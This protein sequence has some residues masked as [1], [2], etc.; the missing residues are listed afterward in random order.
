MKK[1]AVFACISDSI[2]YFFT[3]I[4]SISFLIIQIYSIT[5]FTSF[6]IDWVANVNLV[7]LYT[8]LSHSQPPSFSSIFISILMVF[9]IFLLN[10]SLN[11]SISRNIILN[12]PFNFNLLNIIQQKRYL[13]C[14]WANL[15]MKIGIYLTSFLTL[16]AFY[17]LLI[18][19]FGMLIFIFSFI[20]DDT[21]QVIS[22]KLLSTQIFIIGIIVIF[23]AFMNIFIFSFFGVRYMYVSLFAILDKKAKFSE[24]RKITKGN[25][26]RIFWVMLI[27]MIMISLLHVAIIFPL[28]Y[29]VTGSIIGQTPLLLALGTFMGLYLSIFLTAAIAFTYR[30]LIQQSEK[31]KNEV[32][33]EPSVHI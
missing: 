18:L 28:S 8:D 30:S 27:I 24:S 23:I 3:N 29:W 21:L 22:E 13:Y 32:I 19:F 17:F 2:R 14:F 31:S 26:L 25:R 6:V 10:I 4:K 12:E 1:L 7:H 15:K 11:I 9:G 16:L 20:Q 33:P 5:I